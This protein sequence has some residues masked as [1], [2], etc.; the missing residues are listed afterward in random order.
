MVSTLTVWA[1]LPE[2][3][4]AVVA[5]GIYLAG[6]FVRERK[7]WIY[8]A[9]GA[10]VLAGGALW[11]QAGTG[12]T[13]GPIADDGLAVFIRG[14]SLAVGGLL[15][16]LQA[17][18]I[19]SENGPESAGTL[20]LLI[21]GL[22]LA[23]TANDLVLLFLGLELVSIPTYILLAV[24][25]RGRSGQE[26]TAKYFFLSL[27]S[28]AV[29][30]YGLSF[31]YG[32]AGSTRLDE[33]RLALASGGGASPLVVST[34][35]LALVLIVAGLG[36]RMAAVPFHFYAPDVFQGTTNAGAA[37]LAVVPKVAGVAAFARLVI[38]AMPGLE[39]TGWRVTMILAVL[40]MSVGN[41][42]ALLQNDLRRL[43]AYSS[44]AH[45]GYLLIGLA[46]GLTATGAAAGRWDGLGS[47]LLYLTMYAL[48][49]IGTFAA[50]EWLGTR[51]A[52]V[53][54]V[55]QLAGLGRT[56]PLAAGAVAVFMFSLAGIP[57][58]AGFWGKLALFAGAIN[59]D[60]AGTEMTPVRMWFILLAVA[61]VLNSAVAAGYY[62]RIVGVM[63]FGRPDKPLA[64]E[65]GVGPRV[66]MVASL[67]LVLLAGLF[68]APLIGSTR[69][70][71]RFG[72][73]RITPTLTAVQEQAS[74]VRGEIRP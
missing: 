13:T 68:P 48:A 54:T 25:G 3:I 27:L 55:D 59:V 40:S 39:L 7:V 69:Q 18:S 36:F 56:H 70:A 74:V 24:T 34:G 4:L 5:T 50:I 58:L 66:A 41:V 57:P 6:A 29:L 47:S 67:V 72:A 64:G 43:L 20:L 1:L 10:V 62:L 23:G 14:L 38:H 53:R 61:G 12:G 15:L 51:N 73:P 71:G 2:I 28:S 22:M 17:R 16:I 30:L 21:A 9:L 63:Y 26:A 31:L 45:G 42:L 35:S 11:S 8:P 33:I 37:L 65:G 46:V 60:S 32:S 44:I 52:E 19:S 49:T